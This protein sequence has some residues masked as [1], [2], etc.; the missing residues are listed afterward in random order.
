MKSEAIDSRFDIKNF[1]ED[2]KKHIFALRPRRII[3]HWW[4]EWRVG[5]HT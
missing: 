2:E 4:M 5:V 3:K 1:V